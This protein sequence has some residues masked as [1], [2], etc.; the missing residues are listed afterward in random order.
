[1]PSER[2]FTLQWRWAAWA[3]HRSRLAAEKAEKLMFIRSNMTSLTGIILSQMDANA[4]M[5][6]RFWVLSDL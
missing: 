4:V 3:H 6:L 2:L 5:L 1:M